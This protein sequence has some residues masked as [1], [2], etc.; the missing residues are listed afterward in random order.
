MVLEWFYVALLS[1]VLIAAVNIVDKVI[2]SDYNIPPLVYAMVISATSLMPLVIVPFIDFKVL[3]LAVLT[4]T[5]LVGFVRIYY[6]LPYF[7]ALTIEE[8]SRVIPA[9]QLMPVFV[10]ILSTI[11]LREVLRWQDYTGFVLLVIGGTLCA[12]RLKKGISVSVAFYL[13]IASSFLLA[14]YSVGLKV[15]YASQDFYSV[16]IWVQI[17][18][19]ITL[20]QFMLFKPLRS[21]LVTTYKTTRK[22]V[23]VLL[24]GEQAVAYVSVF[25]YNYA[26]AHGSISLVSAVASTQPLFVLLFATAISYWFPRIL[27]EQLT[28]QDIIL[29]CFGIAIIFLGA[30]LIN[31]Y[32]V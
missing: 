14:V 29:K 27:R 13:M 24:V 3:S 16:F 32:Q 4:F 19:F 25:A 26:I 30:F 6:T 15:L 12:I 9:L 11:F 20:F 18:G 2:I 1:S 31:V 8:V 7:K 10:L 17:A 28:R 22:R 5:M 23:G 21:T